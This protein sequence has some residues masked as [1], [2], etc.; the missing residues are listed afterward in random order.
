MK[1]KENTFLLSSNEPVLVCGDNR[2]LSIN[3]TFLIK[4][5]AWR[6]QEYDNLSQENVTYYTLARS[7]ISKD[8]KVEKPAQTILPFE[9]ISG[10]QD[11]DLKAE[12]E[13]P[14]DSPVYYQPGEKFTLSGGQSYTVSDKAAIKLV[15]RTA[16]S[17]TFMLQPNV[18]KVT[19]TISGQAYTYTSVR[20]D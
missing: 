16:N 2:A 1:L 5:Q 11:A 18:E 8:T 19:I 4:N 6:V 15:S 7:T 17:F 14:L 20:K 13:L 3:D 12:G 9:N 10:D